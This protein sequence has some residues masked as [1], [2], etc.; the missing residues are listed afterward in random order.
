MSN[1]V[2]LPESIIE[3]IDRIAGE[4]GRDRFVLDVLEA[5]F[6][7]R[8]VEAFEKVVGSLRDAEVPGWETPESID[9]WVHDLRR[10]WE[11]RGERF[12]GGGW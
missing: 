8:R 11:S 9:R 3:K 4:E 2:T 12:P 5:E 10:E 7:R 6:R 1:V